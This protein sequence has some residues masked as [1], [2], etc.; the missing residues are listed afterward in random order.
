MKKRGHLQDIHIKDL[1]QEKIDSLE[2]DILT[3]IEAHFNEME[4]NNLFH[5]L[6]RNVTL[7]LYQT[8]ENHTVAYEVLSKAIDEGIKAHVSTK[9]EG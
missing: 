3:V 1:T 6:I 8:A 2:E 9:K 5:I 7:A 4:I